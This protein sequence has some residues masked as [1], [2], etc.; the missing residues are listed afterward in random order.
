MDR[1]WD[2]RDAGNEAFREAG[3]DFGM[4]VGPLERAE[5]STGLLIR[6]LS[7]WAQSI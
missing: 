3:G 4:N 2:C 6:K 1:G 7:L 5:L